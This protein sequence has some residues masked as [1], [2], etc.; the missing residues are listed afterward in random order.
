MRQACACSS[1]PATA[2]CAT[3]VRAAAVEQSLQ[4][5]PPP[6]SAFPPKGLLLRASGWWNE[7]R[8]NEL[9]T[10]ARIRL[11]EGSES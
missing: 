3:R 8:A 1:Q 4:H 9:I 11:V 5:S 7:A 10:A 2:T 6:P